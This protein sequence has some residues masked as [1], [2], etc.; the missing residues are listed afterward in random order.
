MVK[1]LLVNEYLDSLFPLFLVTESLQ[2]VSTANYLIRN[3]LKKRD[4]F[5]ELKVFLIYL[6][7][8]KKVLINFK[9]FK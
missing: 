4:V 5:S 3:S 1:Y 9:T 7:N 8:K 2:S 6:L